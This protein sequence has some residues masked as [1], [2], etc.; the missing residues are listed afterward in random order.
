MVELWLIAAPL[1]QASLQ[2]MKKL[3]SPISKAGLT[4]SFKF[5]VPE[6]KVGNLDLLLT[7]SEEL[8]QLDSLAARLIHNMSLWILELMDPDR[9]KNATA[10]GELKTHKKNAQSL[11]KEY[12]KALLADFV[13]YATCFQWDRAKYPNMLPLSSL[14]EIF[15]K[16]LLQTEADFKSR[17]TAYNNLQDSLE[18]L[19]GKKDASLVTRALFDVVK[20][21]DFVLD[22]E[23]LTTLLVVVLKRDY[24]QWEKTYESLS[25]FV[26]PRTS[27]R[28]LDEPE[29]GI[30]TVTLFKRAV[31]DFKARAAK[32]RFTVRNFSFEES[33]KQRK[34]MM[35]LKIQK[36]EISGMFV[37]WLK[38][39]TRETFMVWIHLKA[40]RLFVES[41]LR[42][43]LPV[44]FKALLLQPEKKNSKKLRELLSTLFSHLDTAPAA[45]DPSEGMDIP[46][47]S[48]QEYYPYICFKV[49]INLMES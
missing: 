46:S 5:S 20:E 15:T 35:S 10:N 22:S 28:V 1:D 42:F 38:A 17:N 40:L 47:M 44:N 16:Q 43:G 2:A 32:N 39:Q 33:R 30:F 13:G 8:A 26:V 27:R 6:L 41:V 29:G 49:D 36:K 9:D 19:A 21:E 34:E 24:A 4:H 12:L 37:G 3:S 18:V 31:S 48:S 11:G 25:E 7:V 45:G 23:Y 14:T